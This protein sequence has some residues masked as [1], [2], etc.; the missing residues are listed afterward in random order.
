[1]PFT[2]H[3]R[4]PRQHVLSSAA[5]DAEIET[6]SYVIAFL[7]WL[8]LRVRWRIKPPRRYRH[9][10][11]TGIWLINVDVFSKVDPAFRRPDG[12]EIDH[13]CER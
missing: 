5:M 3:I 13:E 1:M 4:R 9:K 2:Q 12:E 10:G 6:V 8:K 11:P 7:T